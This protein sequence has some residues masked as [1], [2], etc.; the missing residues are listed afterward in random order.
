MA[1]EDFWGDADDYGSYDPALGGGAFG[2]YGVWVDWGEVVCERAGAAGDVF[3]VCGASASVY[4]WGTYDGTYIF[5]HYALGW[6]RGLGYGVD[7]D[8]V[9]LYDEGGKEG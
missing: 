7:P 2:V 4:E 5:K 3:G 1:V 6:Q 8:V 9:L